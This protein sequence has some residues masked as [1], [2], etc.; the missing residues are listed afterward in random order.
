MRISLILTVILL[1]LGSHASIRLVSA[2]GCATECS[3]DLMGAHGL[4]DMHT[5]CHDAAMQRALFLCLATSCHT[6]TYGPALAYSISRCTSLGAPIGSLY[7][8]HLRYSQLD[9]QKP[10]SAP[11]LS[12]FKPRGSPNELS[13]AMDCTA[14]LDGVV[15]LS[16]PPS[17]TS[18]TPVPVFQGGPSGTT[19]PN[20]DL[21][22]AAGPGSPLSGPLRPVDPQS[23]FNGQVNGSP[24]PPEAQGTV[25]GGG[26]EAR[27]PENLST[28]GEDCDTAVTDPLHQSP[29]ES[30]EVSQL[31]SPQPPGAINPAGNNPYQ[32]DSN[33]RNQDPMDTGNAWLGGL[34]PSNTSPHDDSGSPSIG[35]NIPLSPQDQGNWN[36]R[37]SPVG[38]DQGISDENCND[39]SSDGPNANPPASPSSIPSLPGGDDLTCPDGAPNGCLSQGQSNQ[40]PLPPYRPFGSPS[41]DPAANGGCPDGGGSL[42][43][44]VSGGPTPQNPGAGQPQQQQPPGG[45]AP[46]DPVSGQQ[47]SA[48]DADCPGHPACPT[49]NPGTIGPAP[50]AQAPPNTGADSDT[51]AD[52]AS[53]SSG[54]SPAKN[55]NAG[56]CLGPD[57]GPGCS[58]RG[59][60]VPPLPQAPLSDKPPSSPPSSGP[61]AEGTCPGSISDG[62]C[63]LAPNKP[64]P[65][66]DSQYPSAPNLPSTPQSPLKPQSPGSGPGLGSSNCPYGS[67]QGSCSRE[68]SLQTPQPAPQLPSTGSQFPSSSTEPGP[69]QPQPPIS[70]DCPEGG[71][72]TRNGQPC[73]GQRSDGNLSGALTPQFSPVNP[74]DSIDNPVTA[75]N[76]RPPMPQSPGPVPFGQ[77]AHGEASGPS[78]PNNVGSLATSNGGSAAPGLATCDGDCPIA[79]HD[80]D[81]HTS[82]NSPSGLPRSP[83]TNR[84]P[85]T[86]P[87][88]GGPA[89]RPGSE[90]DD[91]DTDSFKRA[92]PSSS[93]EELKVEPVSASFNTLVAATISEPHS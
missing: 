6:M 68:G 86:Q 81:Q 12:M 89:P 18:L 55:G 45:L 14:G 93:I 25:N 39:A 15:T 88:S 57:P 83:T 31:S 75:P 80:A 28:A 58:P 66:P 36:G 7:P 62:V 72:E 73:Q 8:V 56:A 9:Q 71:F 32:T 38:S 63:S 4:P 46:Q 35:A 85:F 77:P 64:P 60:G 22:H 65:V 76:G 3:H 26:S 51:L 50:P 30:P 52:S 21:G 2:P 10:L 53:P 54:Q 40:S 19:F 42:G 69:L 84:A 90:V 70:G 16:I 47:G 20:G 82:S 33:S 61:N 34:A 48:A 11:S 91:C 17:S 74:N 44:S 5:L 43:C 59:S 24:N 41:G 1:A 49:S 13:L 92:I 27:G 23:P 37:V 79:N 78:N 67:G 87:G 29:A